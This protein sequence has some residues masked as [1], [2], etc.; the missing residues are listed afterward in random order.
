MGELSLPKRNR[1]PAPVPRFSLSWFAL[2]RSTW[3]FVVG[4]LVLSYGSAGMQYSRWDHVENGHV[5]P[6]FHPWAIAVG[7]A[8]IVLSF[9]LPRPDRH[10]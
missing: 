2:S 8:L 6:V 9:R 1:S 10:L 3:T 7:I 4:V 5:H